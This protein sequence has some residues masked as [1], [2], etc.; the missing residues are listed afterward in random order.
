MD[1][2]SD[3]EPSS[4]TAKMESDALTEL[5]Y[6]DYFNTNLHVMICNSMAHMTLDVMVKSDC[7]NCLDAKL[8]TSSCMLKI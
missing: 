2:T 3:M 1:A 8:E 4:Y 6:N 5:S 7:S